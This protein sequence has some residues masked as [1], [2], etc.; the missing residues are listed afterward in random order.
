[1]NSRWPSLLEIAQL[2]TNA[3][4]SLPDSARAQVA[5]AQAGLAFV[6]KDLRREL[7]RQP[8]A[9]FTAGQWPA[10]DGA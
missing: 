2:P 10:Q 3:R 5:S 7:C 1:M 9:S 6:L 8:V 4:G